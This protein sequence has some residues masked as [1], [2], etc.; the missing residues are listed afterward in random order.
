[1]KSKINA[2]RF[3]VKK[4]FPI[5]SKWFTYINNPMMAAIKTIRPITR[6]A[7]LK[8]IFCLIPT[9]K[10]AAIVPINEVII[11]GSMTSAGLLAPAAAR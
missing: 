4:F 5:K 1:M 3:V 11:H 9:I 7:L 2:D 10:K 8:L 6:E